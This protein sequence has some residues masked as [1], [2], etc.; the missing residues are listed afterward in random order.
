MIVLL[1]FLLP[2]F[3]VSSRI[4]AN[5]SQDFRCYFGVATHETP[6]FLR[7]SIASLAVSLGIISQISQAVL[8]TLTSGRTGAACPDDAHTATISYFAYVR[9]ERR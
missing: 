3:A 2:Q 4:T 6:G 7:R 8:Q 5:I 9:L 1:S